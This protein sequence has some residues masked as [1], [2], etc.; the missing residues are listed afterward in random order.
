[1]KKLT[2]ILIFVILAFS[3]QFLHADDE[4]TFKKDYENVQIN[5]AKKLKTVKSRAEYN[6]LKKVTKSSYEA[7]LKKYKKLSPTDPVEIVKAKI[8]IKLKKLTE[9]EKTIDA[10]IKKK[11]KWYNNAVLTKVAIYFT[12]M[13]TDQALKLFRPIEK[14]LKKGKDL[15]NAYMF[16][17]MMSK[18]DKEKI[19]F[20]DKFI[21]IKDL[22][23]NMLINRPMILASK[24]KIILKKDKKKAMAIYKQSIEAA[25]DFPRVKKMIESKIAQVKFIG[26]KAPGITAKKWI[27]SKPLTL[28]QLKG[29]VVIIDFW[30]TWCGPCRTVIPV[31]KE[32]YDKYKTKDLVVIG[33]TKLYG[34]YR[35]DKITKGKVSVN[36][37]TTLVEGFLKRH[38]ITYPIALASESAI[39][40]KYKI[41][42][43]PTMIFI[44]KKGN[45]RYV[46]AGS[47]APEKIKTRI[48]ELLSEK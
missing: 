41:I 40:T 33:F 38:K 36:E 18:T 46:E 30:A 35:D 12:Q 10:V 20:I 14:K 21:A 17:A 4:I 24:A 6:A 34:M 27:N 37:E 31:L 32:Q 15:Y 28:D 25:K 45:V 7:L 11:S 8:L 19:E 9:A 43:I 5:F 39:F 22:P 2:I 44:D 42:G 16:F 48:K 29:K 13:K 47:G 26:S 1:M 23:K 3:V